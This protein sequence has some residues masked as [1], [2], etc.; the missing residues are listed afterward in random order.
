MNI[1]TQ[2]E[3]PTAEL[4]TIGKVLAVSRDSRH[5]FSKPPV[6][7]ITL[8][9][10]LGVEGDAHAGA[11]V[12]HTYLVNKN[13]AMPNLRQVHL[14]P[15]ELYAEM[16][17]RGFVIHPGGMGENITTSGLD[18]A[19]LPLGTRLSLGADAVIEVTGQRMP[20]LHID[21]F[22]QGLRREMIERG[23]DGSVSFKSGIMGIVLAGG[24]VIPGDAIR[25][26][27]PPRPWTLLPAI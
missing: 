17:P 7:S 9:A 26:T 5:R 18:L 27:L 12:Q 25:V 10:G 11:L 15:S 6:L 13:P 22:Q 1:G 21:K 23:A 3:A 14:I 24:E 19:H 20:C 4:A 2:P 8:L 16:A